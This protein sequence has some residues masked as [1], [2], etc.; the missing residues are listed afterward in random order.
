MEKIFKNVEKGEEE[1]RRRIYYLLPECFWTT[2]NERT[3]AV[4]GEKKT[5]TFN[6]NKAQGKKMGVCRRVKR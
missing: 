6:K 4:G 1:P 3:T 2:V 5:R